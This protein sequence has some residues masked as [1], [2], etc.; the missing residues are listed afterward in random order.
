VVNDDEMKDSQMQ[1]DLKDPFLLGGCAGAGF[2]IHRLKIEG[3]AADIQILRMNDR[4][5]Q[6][7]DPIDQA[8]PFVWK[9]PSFTDYIF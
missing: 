6:S 1:N 5:F 8:L 2:G 4:F 7:N 3:K 9:V